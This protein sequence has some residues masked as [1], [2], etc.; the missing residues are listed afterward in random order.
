MRKI[1]EKIKLTKVEKGM[2][3]GDVANIAIRNILS[4]ISEIV[5]GKYSEEDKEKTLEY[6]GGKC[7]YTNHIIKS[8]RYAVDHIVPQNIKYCGLN[9]K[10][11]LILVDKEANSKKGG[12]SVKEFLI[13]DNDFWNKNKTSKKERVKRLKRIE[14]F[15]MDAGYN[16][17]EIYRKIHSELEKIYKEIQNQQKLYINR[18]LKTLGPVIVLKPD[19]IALFK[20]KLLN[21]KKATI[22]WYYMDKKKNKTM[23]WDA[24]N[25]NKT[26]NLL[27]NIQTRPEWKNKNKN[28]LVRVEVIV[29]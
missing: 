9:V 2:E 6:F 20:E 29:K 5:Y 18:V 3:L 25:F 10:G 24:K 1:K 22:K 14:K 26:S 13:N 23:L 28:G 27:G 7:P 17:K 19:N 11:N 4:E 12:K 8:D 21:T 15:Q 16:Y